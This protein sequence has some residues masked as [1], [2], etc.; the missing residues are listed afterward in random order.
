MMMRSWWVALA[1]LAVPLLIWA[2]ALPGLA[3]ASGNFM[4]V[5]DQA[6]PSLG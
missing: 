4:F 2:A 1:A 5:A 3:Q 6:Q